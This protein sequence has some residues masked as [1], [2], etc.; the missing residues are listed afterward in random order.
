[1]SIFFSL[2]LLAAA[3]WVGGMFFAYVALRP[4]AASLLE[5]PIRLAL[6]A[7]VLNRFFI[8]VWAF[9]FI[10]LATGYYMVFFRFLGFANVGMHVHIMQL[11]GII[12]I[13]IYIYLY[14]VPFKNLKINLSEAKLPDA[15]SCLNTIRKGIAI[16]LSLGLITMFIASTHRF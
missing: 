10:L 3:L 15:A 2:H 11:I 8:W 9:I 1:M 13:F 4:V 12:M 5:P 7:Q 14:F 6:W 16:N